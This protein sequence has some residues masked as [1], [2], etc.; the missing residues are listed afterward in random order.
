MRKRIKFLCLRVFFR[1]PF[2]LPVGIRIHLISEASQYLIGAVIVLVFECCTC[3]RR[4]DICYH[5][6]TL[7][8]QLCTRPSLLLRLCREENVALIH[9]HG[10]RT[11]HLPRQSRLLR[12]RLKVGRKCRLLHLFA[13]CHLLGGGNALEVRHILIEIALESKAHTGVIVL[14]DILIGLVD[15]VGRTVD[16]PLCVFPHTCRK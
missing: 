12:V 2:Q 3:G 1:H 6:S 15:C 4:C 11:I 14:A 7:P 10:R 8:C 9:I 16:E 5:L 13:L